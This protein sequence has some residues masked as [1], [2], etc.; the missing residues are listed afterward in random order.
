MKKWFMLLIVF[1]LLLPFAFAEETDSPAAS[2]QQDAAVS[3]PAPEPSPEPA[4]APVAENERLQLYVSEDLAGI[5][6]VDKQTGKTWSS[7][8]NDETFSW[9]KVNKTWE[10]RMSSLL[11]LN[12]TNLSGGLGSINSMALLADKQYAA[13]CDLIDNGVRL[14]YSFGSCSISMDVEITL[15]G[16]SLLVR[17]PYDSIQENDI[18]AVVSVDVMPFLFSASDNADGYFFYPDGSGA[19]MEFKD[20]AH[21]NEKT[22][23]YSVYGALEKHESLK[24]FFTPKSPV[25]MLPVFGMNREGQGMLAVIENGDETSRISVNCSSRI[26]KA[27]YLFANFQYRRGFDDLR[28]TDRSFKIYDKQ[29]IKTDY[30]LRILFLPDGEN[31]YS[32]MATA[33]RNY[34]LANGTLT[35]EETQPSV[36][37]DIFL[38]TNEEGLLIDEPRTVTTLAQAKEMLDNFHAAGV[39]SLVVS[40]KGW[41]HNGY[42]ATPDRFP[43]SRSVGGDKELRTLLENA[44]EYGYSVSLTANFL[45]AVKE[46][47]GYSKRN[48]VIYTGNYAILTNEDEDLYLLSP[49]VVQDKY[50]A[51]EKQASKLPL[52]GVRFEHMGTTLGFN[53]FSRRPLTAVQCIDIY[54][55]MMQSCID[56]FGSVSV[57]GGSKYVLNKASLLTEIPMRDYGFQLTTDHVPFYQMVVH[58]LRAYTGTPGN[59]SSDLEREVLRWVEMGYTPYFELAWGGTEE[60]MY[61][62]YQSLFSA[63]CEDWLPEVQKVAEQFENGDLAELHNA[64]MLHHD[65]LATD[66]FR[67][68]YDNGFAVYVNYTHEDVTAD[69]HVIPARDYV[70]V[71]EASK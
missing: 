36:A 3:E 29:S 24:S 70:I 14:H 40:L 71:K 4:S 41:S 45:E 54:Q 55:Q 67:V 50:E 66:V 12:Y 63:K 7:S 5:D 47:G 62:S 26:V 37:L 10:K 28:V 21:L 48:D 44:D 16:D 22:Q 1:L 25:V 57:Q 6:I 31:D 46:E 65:K 68:I 17:I 64:L 34:L 15:E 59:L 56:T 49:D 42:G 20:N 30:A 60:L 52:S 51:F 19:I 23:L 18:Y 58:G 11:S 33:Y 39:R 8:M 9:E 61:T 27:N 32:A 69:G 43:I 2:P 53:Y 13:S 38:T 35:Q